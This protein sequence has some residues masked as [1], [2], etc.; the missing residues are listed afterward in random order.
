MKRIVKNNKGVLL[1]MFTHSPIGYLPWTIQTFVSSLVNMLKCILFVNGSNIYILMY[2]CRKSSV[3]YSS[4][5]EFAC[6]YVK[7][8]TL[9]ERFK[10]LHV[11]YSYGYIKGMTFTRSFSL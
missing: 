3:D 4:I 11:F 6:E 2:E 8:Y 5:C 7:M 10:Y 9:H 1:N